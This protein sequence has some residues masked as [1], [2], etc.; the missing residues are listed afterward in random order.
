MRL[1][2]PCAESQLISSIAKTLS[3]RTLRL[4]RLMSVLPPRADIDGH[5]ANVRFVRRAQPVSATPRV[6]Y[7][8]GFRT[9]RSCAGVD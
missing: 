9:P 4:V 8:Q 2:I 7:R 5:S 3:Q 1:L 6:V